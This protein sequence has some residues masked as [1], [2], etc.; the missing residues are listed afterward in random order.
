V[1]TR[2]WENGA[3]AS[4]IT[5][6]TAGL[7]E[8]SMA[9]N[10]LA[11]RQAFLA[12]VAGNTLWAG[13]YA[14][15]K[16]ALGALSPVELNAIRFTLAAI[17]L[18]PVLLRGWRRIPRD[19][20]TLG[21]LALATLL[22]WVLNKIFEYSGLALST[23]SDV[24]L[25]IATESL[26]T[27]L[28]SWTLLREQ[29]TRAGV[30]ALIVGLVGAYLIVARGLVPNLM[31]TGAPGGPLPAARIAGDLLVVLS[32]LI[33]AG[34]TVRGKA[35]L[36][37]VPPLLFT[38]AT[39]TGSLFVWIPAGAAAFA[40]SGM[41]RISPVQWLAIFY[42]AAV[43]TVTAY[44]LWFRGLSVLDASAAAPTL[45]IQPLLGAAIAIVLLHDTL[46]WATVAGAILIGVSL[47]LV[48]RGERRKPAEVLGESA[49]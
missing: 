25:L 45:F 8:A 43:A 33:E 2:E 30:A 23:A 42:M 37:R 29:V 35:V 17:L 11:R 1:D 18:A 36:S 9:T 12:I 41:P 4:G 7:G 47:L 32:L 3:V 24:A 31:P 49:P 19:R 13:T 6:S 27:A 38:S 5:E 28:L 15:G 34:Y 16:I 20:A 26:F 21:A 39:I 40:V 44:Y 48:V 14:A 22:G 46:T 10:R